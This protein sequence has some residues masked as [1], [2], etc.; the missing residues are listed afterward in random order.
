MWKKSRHPSK[1]NHLL[2][3]ILLLLCQTQ[4]TLSQATKLHL[5]EGIPNSLSPTNVLRTLSLIKSTIIGL[6][7]SRKTLD[8]E[9]LEEEVRNRHLQLS[10][11]I[12]STE[13]LAIKSLHNLRKNTNQPQRARELTTRRTNSFIFRVNHSKNFVVLWPQTKFDSHKIPDHHTHYRKKTMI[14]NGD[15]PRL[16]RQLTLNFVLQLPFR[17]ILLR[18]Q[19]LG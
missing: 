7:N 1:Q 15:E 10:H 17:L 13:S 16:D 5:I 8:S 11:F 12:Q 9:V 18:E 14:P 3:K 6:Q 4:I 19:S 2:E